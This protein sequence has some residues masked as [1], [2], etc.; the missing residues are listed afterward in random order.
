MER[1]LLS[2]PGPEAARSISAPRKHRPARPSRRV[3]RKPARDVPTRRIALALQ[4]GGSH[5]AFTW[6]VLDR[7]LIEPSFEIVGISGTSAGAMNAGILADGLRRGGAARARADLERYWE[8][9][10][11]LPGFASFAP[12]P[13]IGAQ[14][15]WHLDHNPLFLWNDMLRRIWSPYQTNP[16]NYN[17]L[18]QLLERIDFDG[19]RHDADAVRVFICATNVRT[20]LRRVF[21]NAELS[22]DVLLASACLPQVYQAMEIDSEHYWDG[23]Y[24]GNPALAP[25]YLRTKATDVI[26]V[27]INPVVRADMPRTA[28]A[29]IDRVDE[30][31]FNSTFML[32]LAAIAF[33]EDLVQSGSAKAPFKPLF[34][35]GIGDEAL[36]SFGASSKMNNERGFLRRLHEMGKRAADRWLE[37]NR[38]AVG[39]RS[40]LDLTGLIPPKDGSLTGQS[41]IKQKHAP[42]SVP[43]THEV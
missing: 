43:L 36:G 30:I 28:R 23:G 38:A 40:T 6:G 1:D 29:I 25:L 9:V 10:G 34:V 32:E 18:R 27:G 8:D 41:T 17:P 2:S 33:V 26:V 3:R 19:L 37:D 24:T 15:T 12:P 7:L 4:G 5:G 22:L 35:H 20:G 11:R 21:Q 14:P 39:S 16:V 13:A 31:S 42:L